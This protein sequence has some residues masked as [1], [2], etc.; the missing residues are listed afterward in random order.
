MKQGV[1]LIMRQ[2]ASVVTQ[3]VGGI[4]HEMKGP[5]KSVSNDT[6][7]L[8]AHRRVLHVCLSHAAHQPR[9][10]KAANYV[11]TTSRHRDRV[12]KTSYL[13][14]TGE[15]AQCSVQMTRVGKK[16]RDNYSVSIAACKCIAPNC[17]SFRETVTSFEL[18]I[19]RFSSFVP[20]FGLRCRNATFNVP[21]N[22]TYLEKKIFIYLFILQRNLQSIAPHDQWI[23]GEMSGSCRLFR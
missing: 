17:P 2:Y 23:M 7:H 14:L 11:T 21:K 10:Q 13:P 18:F 1:D 19:P 3:G 5:V 20:L 6:L 16:A 12:S 9:H 15:S 8:A 22:C 4:S